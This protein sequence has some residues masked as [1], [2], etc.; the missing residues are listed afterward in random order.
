MSLFSQLPQELHLE[1]ADH[2]PITSLNALLRTNHYFFALLDKQ[3][4]QRV[5]RS[6]QSYEESTN[7]P[8]YRII[9]SNRGRAL[10]RLL[11]LGLKLSSEL[12]H[13]AVSFGKLS[14][15]RALLDA[16]AAPLVETR[17]T[18]LHVACCSDPT[19]LYGSD[20]YWRPNGQ[21]KMVELL[22]EYGADVNAL[23]SRGRKPLD[24]AVFAEM[25]PLVGLLLARGADPG[26]RF[27]K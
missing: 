25:W 16:G 19:G 7:S 23:D 18:L 3:L 10:S 4:H 6:H 15:V 12:V 24:D 14:A 20:V 1:I 27:G 21:L 13:T 11:E 17:T 5:A 26:E 8:V 22:L 9:T 2:L